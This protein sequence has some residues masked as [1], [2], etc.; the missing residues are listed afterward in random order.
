MN[1]LDRELSYIRD[2]N[3]QAFTGYV[4]NN[5]PAYFWEIPASSTGKFHPDFASGTGGL[6]RHTKAAVFFAKELFSI[7]PK[8]DQTDQDLIISALI[9]HDGLKCGDPQEKFTL[10]EHPKL[11]AEKIREMGPCHSIGISLSNTLADMVESHSGRWNTNFHSKIILPLPKDQRAHFV[12]LCD[13]LA[14]RPKI[15]I[16]GIFI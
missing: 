7:H 10:H 1:A 12:H 4:L 6:V 14:S 5:I 3:I 15:D 9:L 11:M 8:L 2:E 13:F 16:Q